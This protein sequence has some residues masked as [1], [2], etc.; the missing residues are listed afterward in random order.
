ML[1]LLKGF[2]GLVQQV[3]RLLADRQLIDAG[4]AEQGM[5]DVKAVEKEVAVAEAVDRAVD[6][7]RDKRLR[8]R[9]DRGG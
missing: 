6:P 2:F 8:K 5:D 3:F 4:K 7:E 9:F 1:S